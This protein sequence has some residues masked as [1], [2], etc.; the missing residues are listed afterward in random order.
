MHGFSCLNTVFC[1]TMVFCFPLL[2]PYPIVLFPSLFLNTQ[3]FCVPLYF[4]IPNSYVSNCLLPYQ[5]VLCH[6]VFFQTQMFCFLLSSSIICA[7][8]SSSI[9][10]FAL[11]CFLLA[12][13]VKVLEMR[14][15]DSTQYSQDFRSFFMCTQSSAIP[16]HSVTYFI[17]PYSSVLSPTV[18]C[19]TQE[20]CVTL[21][22][23]IPRSYASYC[24]LPYPGLL[25][26][27]VLCH[28]YVQ[29]V[30]FFVTSWGRAR[31]WEISCEKNRYLG[32]T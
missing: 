2:L 1:H 24:I 21:Y 18:F 25:V 16:L 15:V 13:L 3:E 12:I 17:I 19:H 5:R 28:T 23:A 29:G 10:W 14:L 32:I 22:S 30:I 8:L 11:F 7:T 6:T 4:T 26:T 31:A 9:P 20:L 27:A